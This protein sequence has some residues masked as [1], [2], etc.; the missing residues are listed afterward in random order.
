M[1]ARAVA[2]CP[3]ASAISGTGRKMRQDC[4][5]DDAA[6]VGGA[7]GEGAWPRQ[8]HRAET[9]DGPRN[10]VTWWQL[11]DTTAVSS[12]Q[13]GH[14]REPL[15]PASPDVTSSSASL[16][17]FLSQLPLPSGL[18]HPLPYPGES[19]LSPYPSPWFQWLWSQPLLCASCGC[20]GLY[21]C[22]ILNTKNL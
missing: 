18:L 14:C 1:L 6:T 3:S 20:Q 11:I 12:T 10:G 22:I 9:R 21:T 8:E 19:L 16:F 2:S 17:L 5:A 7:G 13:C 15:V 4:S